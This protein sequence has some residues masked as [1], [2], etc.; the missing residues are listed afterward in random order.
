MWMHEFGWIGRGNNGYFLGATAFRARIRK[1]DS[2]RLDFENAYCAKRNSVFRA[3]IR[4]AD[5][6]RPK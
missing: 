4:K 2:A 5:S 3:R 6:A 1:A